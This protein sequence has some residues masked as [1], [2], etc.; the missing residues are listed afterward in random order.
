MSCLFHVNNHICTVN[1]Y[2]N[3]CMDVYSLTTCSCFYII[4]CFQVISS[5]AVE[6]VN[7]ALREF[8]RKYN[9]SP[10][11]TVFLAVDEFVYHRN[12]SGSSTCADLR[13]FMRHA[14]LVGTCTDALARAPHHSIFAES[15]GMWTK[16]CSHPDQ[17]TES[18]VS[19]CDLVVD[20][21]D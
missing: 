7:S 12:N 5:N 16:V 9:G 1:M 21:V 14:G 20:V 13:T 2:M 18:D 17:H 15:R 3:T 4:S 10:Y 11:S 6:A 19:D 8:L